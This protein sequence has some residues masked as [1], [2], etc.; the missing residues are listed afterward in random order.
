MEPQGSVLCSY[1]P[2]ILSQMK[3]VHNLTQHYFH[4]IH[5]NNILLKCFYFQ[6]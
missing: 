3:L 2:T 1:E 5:L 4:K 6:T